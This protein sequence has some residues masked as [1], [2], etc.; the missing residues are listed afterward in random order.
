MKDNPFSENLVSVLETVLPGPPDIQKDN[1]KFEC[2]ICYAQY[3]PIDDDL[4]AKSGSGPDYTCDNASCSKAFHSLCLGDWLRSITTTRQS[5]DVLF[6]SCPYCSE[7]VAV[8][9]NAKE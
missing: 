9:V 3:L 5:F 1:Q 8:K 6:G 2:G 4:G 7:P